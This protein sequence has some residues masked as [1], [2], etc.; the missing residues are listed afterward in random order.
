MWITVFRTGTH[1][2][3]SGK[4]RTWTE[5]DLDE[6][7]RKYDPTY[8][9]APVVIGHP[10][11]NAPAWGWVEALKREGQ[12]LYAKLKDLAPEFVE[13]LK[14]GRF[15]KRS[16][17]LY[18][19][20]ALRHIGF[21]GAVPPAVKGLPDVAFK[22]G[23]EAIAIEMIEME[24]GEREKARRAQEARSRRYGI[25]IKEGGNVTK[26]S[27]W[28]SV[29]DEDFLD[30]VNYRYPCPDAEQT[31]AAAS[32]WGMPRNKEQYSPKER[33]I[34]ERRL[35]A[36]LKKFRIGRY[37]KEE[38]SMKE[39]IK[40][41]LGM[42]I[43]NLP[44][45]LDLD[46]TASYS[47]ADLARARAEAEA[48]A[49]AEA[50]RRTRELEAQLKDK[51]AQLRQYAEQEARLKREQHLSECRAFLEGLKTKGQVIPAW[52]KMGLV[53]FLAA[54][55]AS[56]ELEFAEGLKT[57]RGQWFRRFLEELPKVVTFKEVA[58]RG[59]SSAVDTAA[60]RNRAVQEYME[61]TGASLKDAFIAVKREHPELFEEEE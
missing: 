17:S 34:I 9:E 35:E 37:R 14:Q 42:A 19:D 5:Q 3:S 20:L 21:L 57:S 24:E 58:K 41:L 53:E 39:R 43:D 54:L 13:M 16:I 25:G 45:D 36:K 32:Y 12:L 60:A 49:K 1:T 18:N 11:D 7:V 56:E 29:P 50:E 2:D 55:D 59:E 40:R 28:Q 46:T 4:T 22:G 38:T 30:P 48:A 6:I 23:D 44:E 33:D 15:K 61:K 10:K 47:E 31:R 8:N 27:E 52:E 26:P 51:E